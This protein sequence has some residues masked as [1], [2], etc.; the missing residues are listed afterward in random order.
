MLTHIDENGNATMVD[1]SKKIKR[2]ELQRL[3]EP[4]LQAKK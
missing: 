4:S 2:L 1:I 3:K